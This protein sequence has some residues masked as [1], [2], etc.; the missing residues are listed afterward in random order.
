MKF[1]KLKTDYGYYQIVDC[2]VDYHDLIRGRADEA[3]VLCE[4]CAGVAGGTVELFIETTV[5]FVPVDNAPKC[6][7][8]GFWRNEAAT[9]SFWADNR[10]SIVDA[11]RERHMVS[12]VS[13]RRNFDHIPDLSDLKPTRYE[14]HWDDQNREGVYLEQR[15]GRDGNLE[16]VERWA[17]VRRG[18][19]LGKT[20]HPRNGKYF[21]QFE[22]LP[23]TRMGNDGYMKEYR[24]ES[25]EAALAFWIDNRPNIVATFQEHYDFVEELRAN[26]EIAEG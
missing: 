4:G 24:F 8:C 13:K 16:T 23:S 15:R 21:F 11:L 25:A 17:I 20:P 10:S 26:K 5:E 9:V 3:H 19:V 22:P 7:R 2:A 14:L 1:Y 6:Q 12:S 18:G